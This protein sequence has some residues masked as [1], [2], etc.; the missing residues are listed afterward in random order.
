MVGRVYTSLTGFYLEHTN[1]LGTLL[2]VAMARYLQALG[3][4]FWDFDTPMKYK[5]DLGCDTLGN[6]KLL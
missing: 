2:L 3:F 5:D 1:Q 4:A 6:K